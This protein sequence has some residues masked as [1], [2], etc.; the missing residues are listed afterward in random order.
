MFPI[1]FNGL[2]LIDLIEA[3][4]W[5]Q[6]RSPGREKDFLNE[7]ERTLNIISDNPAQ[8]R[9]IGRSNRRAIVRSYPY[10]IFYYV[11]QDRITI[12]GC[13]HHSRDIDRI[14]EERT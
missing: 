11:L 9:R 4:A 14:L 12:I 13:L 6:E 2:A 10:S 5:Y 8:Y 1:I 3:A 7:I